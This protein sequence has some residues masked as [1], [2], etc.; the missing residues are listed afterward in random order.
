VKAADRECKGTRSEDGEVLK[1]GGGKARPNTSGTTATRSIVDVPR[2][3]ETWAGAAT[4]E[5]E[6]WQ[7]PARGNWM[8]K[9]TGQKAKRISALVKSIADRWR[10]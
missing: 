4:A 2:R 3:S 8:V 7:R 6:Y 1:A 9:R 10:S 5:A